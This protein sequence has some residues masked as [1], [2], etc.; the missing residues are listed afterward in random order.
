MDGFEA[1]M[2]SV[3]DAEA[4]LRKKRKMN[5]RRPARPIETDS[6][7]QQGE[8]REETKSEVSEISSDWESDFTT[9]AE[10]RTDSSDTDYFP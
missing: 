7:V 10:E 2:E 8:S 1:D 9:S 6:D 4:P 5:T 3:T